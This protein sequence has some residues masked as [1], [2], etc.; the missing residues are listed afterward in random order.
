ML[1]KIV[2]INN[3]QPFVSSKKLIALIVTAFFTG[4]AKL[5]RIY[6]EREWESYTLEADAMFIW[7]FQ[8]FQFWQ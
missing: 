8:Q 6:I 2:F 4:I 1:S 5:N 3:I 7:S